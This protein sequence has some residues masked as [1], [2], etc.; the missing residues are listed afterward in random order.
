MYT[1]SFAYHSTRKAYWEI[2]ARDQS[3]FNDRIKRFAPIINIILEN[4][5]REN[6]YRLRFQE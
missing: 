5:H 1:W 4:K 3:R 2:Y 6:I